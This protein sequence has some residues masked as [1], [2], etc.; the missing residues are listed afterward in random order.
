MPYRPAG[1]AGLIGPART[2]GRAASRPPGPRSAATSVPATV[3]EYLAALPE[4]ARAVLQQVRAAV[5]RGL[6]GA[7][8]TIRHGMPAAVP[9]SRYG[10][11]HAAW[12]RHA[13]L[14]PVPVLDGELEAEVAPHR[15]GEDPVHLPYRRPV[16]EDLVDR[17]AAR[18]P[19]GA[20][21]ARSDDR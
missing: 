21:A 2:P 8:E 18:R 9:G 15:S 1:D 5:L 7:T 16:P 19:D 11:H 4:E 3:D 20:A 6:P 10:L 14:H 13:A 17:I 12:E